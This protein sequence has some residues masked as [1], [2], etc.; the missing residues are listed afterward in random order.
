VLVPPANPPA[1]PEM[2]ATVARADTGKPDLAP[3]GLAPRVLPPGFEAK[4]EA[5]VHESG[6]PLAILGKRDHSTMVLVPGGTFIMGSDRD[7]PD[8]APAHTVRVSTFYIDQ[9]EVTNHQFRTFLD[10]RHYR[11]QPPGKWLTDEKLRDA[12]GAA[13]A[14]YVNYHDAEQFALWAGKRLATEAQWEMAARSGDGRRYPW[15][16][17]PVQWSR[18]R[19]FHQVD[20]VMSFHEDV[21]PYGVFDMA[22]NTMEWVRDWYDP[23][24]F[25]KMKGKIVEDPTGPPSKRFNSIQ[26][27]VK[28]GSKN[29]IVTGREG[30]DVDRRLP[31][32]GFR[33]TL[34]V[35]GSE[36]AAGIN[37][38]PEKAKKPSTLPAGNAPAGNTV[39]F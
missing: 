22:G 12:P 1:A 19:E 26:R 8:E 9:Y 23:R 13:P 16:D 4:V 21:S 2:P 6:W 24:Y 14:V 39:P 17:Q 31:Y 37:P 35:E 5:G 36:A 3:R 33:C 11:G 34:A 28:G 7:E 20:P 30:L 38:H 32:L 10:E 29:W 27:V 15:G 18:R 25:E